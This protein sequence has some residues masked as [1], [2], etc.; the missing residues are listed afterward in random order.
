MAAQLCLLW[1]DKNNVPGLCL[2]ETLTY[3]GEF[4]F[5]TQVDDLLVGHNPMYFLL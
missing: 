1:N 5:W 3:I 4:F 2:L